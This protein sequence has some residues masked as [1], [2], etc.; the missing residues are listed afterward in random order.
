M[1]LTKNATLTPELL[2][3]VD[4]VLACPASPMFDAVLDF[5]LEAV[6]PRTN[7]QVTQLA[8]TSD[9]FL[10][11]WSNR[12]PFKEGMVGSTDDFE[13]N[14]RGIAKHVGLSTE[15]AEQVL[16]QAYTHITDWR[17]NRRGRNPYQKKG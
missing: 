11:A 10:M 1:S 7:P 14:V 17:S 12:S 4:R 3:A 5:C 16:T 15:L 2:A 8:I 9:G 13:R 6:K